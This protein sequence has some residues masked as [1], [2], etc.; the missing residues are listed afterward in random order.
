[1]SPKILLKLWYD[2]SNI[3]RNMV[4]VQY[5]FTKL[6]LYVF[7]VGFRRPERS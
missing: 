5:P 7:T 2:S 6:I 4:F 1:M 3:F